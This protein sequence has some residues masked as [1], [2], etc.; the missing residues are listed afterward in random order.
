MRT[1]S[2]KTRLG[3]ALLALGATSSIV[4][5]MSSYAYPEAP[6]F[7]WGELAHGVHSP[8]CSS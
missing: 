3:A 5:A 1:S 4:W 7:M 6:P 2:L 8:A